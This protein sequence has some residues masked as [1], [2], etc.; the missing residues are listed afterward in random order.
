MIIRQLDQPKLTFRHPSIW[1]SSQQ[2]NVDAI[3]SLDPG[4][5]ALANI[6]S[7]TSIN[8]NIVRFADVDVH[9]ATTMDLDINSINGNVKITIL[10]SPDGKQI[11]VPA[12]DNQHTGIQRFADSAAPGACNL[13]V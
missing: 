12:S 13:G 10:P 1:N 7:R 4:I 3:T 11:A 5:I 9:V 6:D 2:L 8:T